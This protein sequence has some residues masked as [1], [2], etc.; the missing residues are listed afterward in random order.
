MSNGLG[1]RVLSLTAAAGIVAA[2]WAAAGCAH[3]NGAGMTP[4]VRLAVSE[5][6]VAGCERVTGVRVTGARNADAARAELQ[7]LTR[8]RG[9][10]VLLVP[11]SSDGTS[12]TAYKCSE[13]VAS[14]P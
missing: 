11:S 3:S 5:Q 10:N 9:G 14:A 12:G 1:R 4:G 2:A 13:P 7:K 6:E 8:D